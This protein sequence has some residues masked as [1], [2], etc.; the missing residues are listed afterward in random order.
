MQ[1]QCSLCT[2]I[3][4]LDACFYPCPDSVPIF[5]SPRHRY[6]PGSKVLTTNLLHLLSSPLR[7]IYPQHDEGKASNSLRL[8]RKDESPSPLVQLRSTPSHLFIVKSCIANDQ[9]KHKHI[10]NDADH[11]SAA[12]RGK[13]PSR[14]LLGI[15]S[16]HSR[17]GLVPYLAAGR[18]SPQC[19]RRAAAALEV[20]LFSPGSCT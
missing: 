10:Y 1:S 19:I 5:P 13:H 9:P 3:D 2:R 8:P 12:S 16:T 17:E 20:Q 4:W 11:S 18:C 6:K 14:G 7:D 15:T